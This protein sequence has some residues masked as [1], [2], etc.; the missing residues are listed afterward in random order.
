MI[1]IYIK[2]TIEVYKQY[3]KKGSVKH[4]PKKKKK[5]KKLKV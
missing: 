1:Y 3:T 5:K 2:K 4:K